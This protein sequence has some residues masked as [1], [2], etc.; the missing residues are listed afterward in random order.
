MK[1]VQFS[2]TKLSNEYVEKI[3]QIAE[4]K[5]TSDMGFRKMACIIEEDLKNNHIVDKK[6]KIVQIE[7]TTINL[8]LKKL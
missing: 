3:I 8:I 5:L 7:K 4:V 2:K 6:G 1:T